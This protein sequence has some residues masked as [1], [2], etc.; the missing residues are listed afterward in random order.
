[1][2]ARAR[3][4]AHTPILFST[5]DV[6]PQVFL[7]TALSFGLVNLKPLA[8]GHVLIC[9]RRVVARLHELTRPEVSDLFATVQRV[10]RMLQRVYRAPAIN[11]A[12]QD[13]PEAG[14][15]VPHLHAHLIPRRAADF[16]AVPDRIYDLLESGEATSWAERRARAPAWVKVPDGERVARE[17]REMRVEAA[18]LA[19][20]M[21][22]EGEGVEEGEGGALAD[23][24]C[25][26][27]EDGVEGSGPG[28]RVVPP[29][30][31]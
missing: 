21:E 15:T 29:S 4:R 10:A 20:A 25:H 28:G 7:T 19:V 8:P 12:L 14:Q 13:G 6:R 31:G 1:M 2:A 27:H 16:D 11:I 17:E 26:E 5:I 23:D 18:D 24:Q 22:E 3:A 30:S 9:P